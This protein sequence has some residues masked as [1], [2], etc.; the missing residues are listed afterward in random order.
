[1]KYNELMNLL[2][3]DE[4]ND[5]YYQEKIIDWNKDY[6]YIEWYNNF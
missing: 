4:I 6:S 5:V 3:D 1:M 2:S